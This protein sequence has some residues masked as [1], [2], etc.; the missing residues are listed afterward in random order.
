M[1]LD[2]HTV[3]VRAADGAVRRLKTKHILIATGAHAVKLSIPGAVRS[4]P[5]VCRVHGG[6]Q[7]AGGCCICPTPGPSLPATPSRSRGALRGPPA[8][9]P[10]PPTPRSRAVQ[11]HSMTSDDALVL[12]DYP[13]KP[14]V[15]LG[16]G[17][18]AVEFAGIFAGLGARVHLMY[19]APLPLRQ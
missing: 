19:R 7:S 4:W 10:S 11:E 15:V 1:V 17:Y 9:R 6:T 12:E 18:I 2:P 5:R 8:D 14:I 13:G 16:A 3:E